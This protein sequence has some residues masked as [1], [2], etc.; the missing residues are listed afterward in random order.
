MNSL[1]MRFSAA[2][3]I[4]IRLITIPRNPI[5]TAFCQVQ[6]H[7]IAYHMNL[8]VNSYPLST[9]IPAIFRPADTAAMADEQ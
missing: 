3:T 9:L 7:S 5:I 1:D 6:V 2:G 8:I 4:L